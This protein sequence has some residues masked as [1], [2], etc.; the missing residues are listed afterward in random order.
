MS[1][2]TI[3]KSNKIVTYNPDLKLSFFKKIQIRKNIIQEKF[4]FFRQKNKNWIFYKEMIGDIF[5]YSVCGTLIM[6]PFSSTPMLVGL[7][8]GSG[9][10]LYVNRIHEKIK[11]ILG[12]I[13]LVNSVR[14]EK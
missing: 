12:S 14:Y 4:K 9:I 6:L 3:K 11:E 5:I 1:S 7:S 13:K 2:E 8:I 10:W